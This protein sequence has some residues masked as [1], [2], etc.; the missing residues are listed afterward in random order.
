MTDTTNVED[1]DS[2]FNI[3]TD[4]SFGENDANQEDVLFRN[5]K[6]LG[7]VHPLRN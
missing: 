7:V 5:N 2:V 4:Y 1:L 3:Q 6:Y